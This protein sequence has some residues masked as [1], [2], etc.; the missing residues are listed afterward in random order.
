MLLNNWDLK[1][2]NNKI[3]VVP[4]ED[5]IIE[6]RY[7]VRD[8]GAAFG[9]AKQPRVLSW[10]PFMRHMQGS[11]NNLEEFESQG[12][13]EEIDADTVTFDY[14]GLDAALADSVTPD[15]LVWTC[16]LLSRLSERQWNDAFR[17]GGYTP[18]QRARFVRKIQEEVAR[19]QSRVARMAGAVA[20]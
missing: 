11:K 3:Y 7:V 20:R 8:L 16:N 5:G 15:D 4:N 18:E 12:F 19:A 6:R 17:A 2:S 9:K 13:V 10:L 14:R 1:T